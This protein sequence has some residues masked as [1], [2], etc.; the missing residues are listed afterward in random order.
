MREY[1]EAEGSPE[2]IRRDK[3]FI[4]AGAQMSEYMILGLRKTSG[5]SISGF[6]EKFN[7]SIYEVFGEKIEKF[8]ENGLLI[9][10]GDR[11]FLSDYGTDVSNQVFM[12]FL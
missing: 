3:E 5:V 12:E 6:E 9:N 11:L 7:A 2:L 1:I 8:I 10:Q 4:D